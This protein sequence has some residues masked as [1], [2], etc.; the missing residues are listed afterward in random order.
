[1]IQEELKN[2]GLKAPLL[3]LTPKTQAEIDAFSFGANDRVSVYN[4]TEERQEK[5]N[6]IS[7]ETVFNSTV[8]GEPA[9]SSTIPNVVTISQ[10]NYD[11]GTPVA[12]TWYVIPV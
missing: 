1:M 6:G 2:G 5:W 10:A 11:L 8:I 9:G 7:W 3:S 4:L 12:T